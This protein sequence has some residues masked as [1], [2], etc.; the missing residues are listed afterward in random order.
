MMDA[1]ARV[2]AAEHHLAMHV[3]DAA[4]TGARRAICQGCDIGTR[5]SCGDA[6]GHLPPA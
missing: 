3:F 1:T 5:T 6:A 4:A 2:L